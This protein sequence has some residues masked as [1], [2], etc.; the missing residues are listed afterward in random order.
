ML[1]PLME[2]N[3]RYVYHF[4]LLFIKE[5]FLFDDCEGDNS[6]SLAPFPELVEES[7]S[8]ANR[9]TPL[10]SCCVPRR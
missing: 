4:L 1:S 6:P 2:V 8:I 9:G 5:G 7:F 3:I 10:T